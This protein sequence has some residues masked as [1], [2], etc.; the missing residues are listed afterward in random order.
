MKYQ[1][2]QAY[3]WRAPLAS[4]FVDLEC[5]SAAHS[6]VSIKRSGALK[7]LAHRLLVRFS[8]KSDFDINGMVDIYPL[9]LFSQK[10]LHELLCK[11]QVGC[12]FE[13]I[14]DV[15]AGVG[16][17]TET[18]K[19]LS[20]G[21]I[22]TTEMSTVM[23][24]RLREKGFDCWEEDISET[25][26]LRAAEGHSFHLATLFNV[27][28][29]TSMPVSLLKGVHSLLKTDGLVIIASPLPFRPFYFATKADRK[30]D[31][32]PFI[33]SKYRKPKESLNMPILETDWDTQAEHFLEKVLPANNFK[34]L[35]FSRIPY[36]SAGDFFV[37]HSVLDDIIVVARKM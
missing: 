27:L 25:A 17:V 3:K 28:D 1:L 34:P 5:H 14:L 26:S 33:G 32:L 35:A 22:T 24:R 30:D 12:H 13:S 8:S 23:A 6:F 18:L 16:E 36:V 19:F 21:R 10:Q 37:S 31:I 15:G 2:G 9:H 4:I 29:R 11:A 7:T 20:R